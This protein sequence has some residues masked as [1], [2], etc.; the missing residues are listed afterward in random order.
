[1][2]VASRTT[3]EVEDMDSREHTEHTEHDEHAGHGPQPK[4]DTEGKD[5]RDPTATAPD[6]VIGSVPDA[7]E[8]AG[9][10]NGPD[11]DAADPPLAG[12]K[13]KDAET[14]TETGGEDDEGAGAHYA[15]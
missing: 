6:S 7:A 5:P 8:N 9:K 4:H 12:E 10:A 2:R 15:G 14:E 13:A 11:P 1:M 3:P